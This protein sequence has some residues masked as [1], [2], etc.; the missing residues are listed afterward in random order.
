MPVFLV[1]FVNAIQLLLGV[2]FK[3]VVYVYLVVQIVLIMAL[4]DALGVLVATIINTRFVKLF[5]L[6][7]ILYQ[8]INAMKMTGLYSIYN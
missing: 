6:L 5:A 4:E 7:D 1:Q 2:Q 3:K 8:V